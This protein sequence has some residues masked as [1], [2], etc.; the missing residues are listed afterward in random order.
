M[1]AFVYAAC[2][3]NLVLIMQLEHLRDS[4]NNLQKQFGDPEL[5]SIYGAGCLSSPEI[6]FVFMNPTGKNV[7]ADQN[8]NGLRAPWIGTKNVW[9]LFFKIGLLPKDIFERTQSLHTSEWTPVFAQELYQTLAD[10]RLYITNLAKCTQRDARPLTNT[11]FRE[12]LPSFHEEIETIAP[13]RIVSFGNQ[14]S[15]IILDQSI[16]VSDVRRSVIQLQIKDQSYSV[17]P[18]F[19]PVGQG[20]RN[21][22][23]AIEDIQWILRQ[24]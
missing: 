6:C 18:T 16:K 15:S 10:Q 20:M 12:Y 1:V 14:I 11:V 8:W 2:M 3:L 17:Y 21:I 23:K 13:K 22:E 5:N 4:F 9:K 19:Y 24:K 7:T